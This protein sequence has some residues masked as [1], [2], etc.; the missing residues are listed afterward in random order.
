MRY[1][2]RALWLAALA[3]A[4][5]SLLASYSDKPK[6][7]DTEKTAVV[8]PSEATSASDSAAVK[9]DPTAALK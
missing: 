8:V 7:T 9:A 6:T 2:P 4:A 3:L 1:A 5:V